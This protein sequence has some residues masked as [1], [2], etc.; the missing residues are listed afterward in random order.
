MCF[1]LVC[2]YEFADNYIFVSMGEIRNISYRIY[3]QGTS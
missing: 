1:V 3:G 2:I